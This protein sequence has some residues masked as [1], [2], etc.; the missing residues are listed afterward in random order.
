ME[1]VIPKFDSS[2]ESSSESSSSVEEA[3][4]PPPKI[5]KIEVHKPKMVD[6]E[7][8]MHSVPIMPLPVGNNVRPLGANEPVQ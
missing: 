5:V 8:T 1:I 2:S 4:T 6:S 3:I 7:T